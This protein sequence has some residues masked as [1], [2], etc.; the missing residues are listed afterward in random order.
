MKNKNKIHYSLKY[1]WFF[2]ALLALIIIPLSFSSISF[3]D[4]AGVHQLIFNLNDKLYHYKKIILL[5]HIFTLTAIYVFSEFKIKKHAEKNHLDYVQIKKI[6]NT[7]SS[8]LIVVLI[9]DLIFQLL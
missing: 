3:L 2:I 7:R 9:F 5:W 6:K 1:K 4:F 8:I